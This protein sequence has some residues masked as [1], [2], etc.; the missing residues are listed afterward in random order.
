MQLEE[1]RQLLEEAEDELQVAEDG[2]LR[3]EVSNGSIQL[4]FCSCITMV[5]M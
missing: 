3:L 5:Y 1:Q 2:R 4:S